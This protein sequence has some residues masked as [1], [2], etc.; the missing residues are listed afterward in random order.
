MKRSRIVVPLAWALAALVAA[1]FCAVG[2]HDHADD[3]QT[4]LCPVCSLTVVDV[5]AADTGSTV[6][7]DTPRSGWVVEEQAPW[8]SSLEFAP[9]A[10]RGPPSV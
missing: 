1:A 7:A 10:P 4:E 8:P 3:A 6:A 5:P 9:D 2:F